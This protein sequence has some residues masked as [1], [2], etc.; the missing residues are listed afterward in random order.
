MKISHYF[1]YLDD[2]LFSKGSLTNRVKILSQTDE[3][4]WLTLPIVKKGILT[5]PIYEIQISR[6][7]ESVTSILHKLRDYHRTAPHSEDIEFIIETASRETFTYLAD[8][9]I[10][11]IK[12][13]CGAI[14]IDTPTLRS[15]E[16]AIKE[17]DATS[18]LVKLCRQVRATRYVGGGGA[19]KYQD[20]SAFLENGIE[21]FVLSFEEP[22]IINLG[23]RSQT[24]LSVLTRIAYDGFD[25]LREA[26]HKIRSDCVIKVNL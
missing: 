21:P 11:M 16:L 20:N 3:L 6:R 7:N 17:C 22:P 12:T 8:M 23:T 24:G 4:R 26:L 19:A 14:G 10:H 18:R 13:I 9:N 25:G 5:A 1:I 2:V 15:S